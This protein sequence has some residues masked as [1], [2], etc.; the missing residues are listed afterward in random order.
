M[1]AFPHRRLNRHLHLFALAAVAVIASLAP[2]ATAQAA[3]TIELVKNQNDGLVT[4][5]T[6]AFTFKT[7][8]FGTAGEQSPGFTW[9]ESSGTKSWSVPANNANATVYRLEELTPPKGWALTGIACT[10]QPGGGAD[11][12]TTT[13]G[14]VATIKVSD[15][16]T[17]RCTFTNAPA[18]CSGVISTTILPSMFEGIDGDQCDSTVIGSTTFDWQT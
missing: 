4:A 10:N 12:D 18:Q 9:S 2:A 7:T 17:V 3:G 5:G 14:R 15:N 6:T 13:S 8:G 16:E 1:N 11:A